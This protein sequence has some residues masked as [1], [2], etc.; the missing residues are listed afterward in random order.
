[1]VIANRCLVIGIS[2]SSTP[3]QEGRQVGL[4]KLQGYHGVE[5]H[6]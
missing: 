3:L 2:A 6:L 1:M 4:Q 5:Y